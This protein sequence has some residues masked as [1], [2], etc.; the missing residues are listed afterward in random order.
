MAPEVVAAESNELAENSDDRNSIEAW[1][2][3]YLLNQVWL[4]WEHA[5]FYAMG[6][7]S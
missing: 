3:E 5:T 7:T 2:A 4:A 6:K 1:T